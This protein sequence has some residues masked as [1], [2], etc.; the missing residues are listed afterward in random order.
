MATGEH[1]QRKLLYKQP[2][3]VELVLAWAKAHFERTGRWPTHHAGAVAEARGENW[4]AIDQAL[5]HGLRGLPSGTSLS[6]LL[7]ERI[8]PEGGKGKPSL[9]LEQVLAWMQAHHGRTG[10]WPHAVTGAVQENPSETW[11]V[12]EQA[13]RSGHRGLPAG[14]SLHLL[15]QQNRWI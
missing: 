14:L 3:S 10:Q 5:R 6:K 11:N 8:G 4:G 1:G 2:L 7:Y 12:I 15:K 9:T 13:L